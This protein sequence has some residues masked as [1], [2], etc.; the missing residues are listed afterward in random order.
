M[1]DPTRDH[2]PLSEE[3]VGLLLDIA[4]DVAHGIERRLTP[5]ASFLLG[6]S[7]QGRMQGGD[8]RA[9]AVHAAIADMRDTFPSV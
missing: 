7:V 4:R 6:M 1:L 8:S 3:E 5:L 2:Q 9:A